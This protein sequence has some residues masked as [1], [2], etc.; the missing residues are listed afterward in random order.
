MKEWLI[1][2]LGSEVQSL[3]P[4]ILCSTFQNGVLIGKLLEN[5]YFVDENDLAR[6]ID[7]DDEAAKTS[8]FEH[9]KSWLNT[10]DITL[11]D[12]T[13]NGIVSGQRPVI[14][15][16][17]YRLCF[18]LESPNKLNLNACAKQ[19]TDDSVGSFEFSDTLSVPETRVVDFPYGQWLA[20]D[21]SSSLSC[22]DQPGKK[23]N[24]FYDKINEFERS[25][26][27]KLDSGKA[28]GDQS[29]IR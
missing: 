12:D 25:L 9:I 13:V 22:S 29:F 8:N 7:R 2:Q 17:L 4:N 15:G 3:H 14:I 28:R 18:A 10:I 6:L 24:A 16:F 27:E 11:D 1:H 19:T 23:P 21:S 20:S 26:P 5:Y